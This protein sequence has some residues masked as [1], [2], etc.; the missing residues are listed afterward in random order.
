MRDAVQKNRRSRQMAFQKLLAG[1]PGG[2]KAEPSAEQ[3][4]PRGV[5]D[6]GLR[7]V[8]NGGRLTGPPRILAKAACLLTVAVAVGCGFPNREKE[9]RQLADAMRAVAGVTGVNNGY[10]N[11]IDAGAGFKPSV[12]VDCSVSAKA[13][14]DAAR[15]FTNSVDT[16]GFPG[17]DVELAFNLDSPSYPTDYPARGDSPY[18]HSQA[19]F[20][21]TDDGGHRINES[22]DDVA[23]GVSLWVNVFQSPGVVSVNLNQHDSSV[24]V[25]VADQAAG[26]ALQQRFPQLANN[27][28]IPLVR[29][30]AA[31]TPPQPGPPR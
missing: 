23:A 19:Q 25:A 15:T 14:S 27:W 18:S 5:K 8:V 2:Q 13:L 24:Q 17:Y 11:G 26:M 1:D 16:I 6:L 31:C 12:T 7:P 22:S 9:A 30:T 20:H 29:T 4:P 21:L 10:Y 3:L 28:K